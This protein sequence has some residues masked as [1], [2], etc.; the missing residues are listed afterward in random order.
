MG[1]R[2]RELAAVICGKLRVAYTVGVAIETTDAHVPILRQRSAVKAIEAVHA[3]IAPGD[4][5]VSM[6][7]GSALAQDEVRGGAHLAVGQ[8]DARTALQHLGALDA[9]IEA[10]LRRI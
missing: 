2:G 5:D 3:F 9:L 7:R 10:K 1:N 8:Y 4:A 6:R